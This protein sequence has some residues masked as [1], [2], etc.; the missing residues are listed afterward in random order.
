MAKIFIENLIIR[1]ELGKMKKFEKIADKILPFAGKIQNQ[2]HLVA[3][4]DA[5]LIVMPLTLTGGFATLINSFSGIFAENGLNIVWL[6]EG[7]DNFLTTTHISS[8]LNL[9]NKGT[10]GMMALTIIIVLTYLLANSMD[11]KNEGLGISA[12]VAALASYLAT[13]PLYTETDGIQILNTTYLGSNGLFVAM[14]I[15]FFIGELFPRL[16]KNKK[17]QIKM[18]EQVP[19]AV[20]RVFSSMFAIV[21]TIFIT[22][23][24]IGF[25]DI[26]T[27]KNLWSFINDLLATPLSSISNSLFSSLLIVG[28]IDILWVL[29]LHGGTIVGSVT[30]V[31][32]KPLEVINAEAFIAG[33]IPPYIYTDLFR[34]AFVQLGGTG[35]TLALI[36]AILFCSKDKAKRTVAKL[37]LPCGLF[38]INEPV[39]F[40]LPIVMNP[41]FAIPFIGGQLILTGATYLLMSI[42]WISRV[43]VAVPWCTPPIL[44]AFLAT[45]G[46][47][48]AAIWATIE[49]IFLILLYIPFVK[50]SDRM[51]Q[52]E[53]V[54][55]QEITTD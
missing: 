29:G 18:P 1:E 12:A 52:S 42:G 32:L 9:I 13:V 48:R 38:M 7:I 35:G 30:N 20:S 21:L 50:I 55:P 22:V 17:L 43:G 34:L 8:I 15:S 47:Y 11:S 14:L 16:G 31:F 4:R 45:G 3:I 24:I 40:G 41:I 44:H 26:L 28:A 37:S 49:F 2:R 46:D 27:G 6:K 36:I 33:Q 54:L 51:I 39:I 5:F 19:A 25:I 53:N 23:S 10:L